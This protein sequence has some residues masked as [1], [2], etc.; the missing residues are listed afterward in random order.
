MLIP[1]PLDPELQVLRE[2]GYAEVANQR[3]PCLLSSGA[4]TFMWSLM[5]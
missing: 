2:A 1:K 5:D 4:L 3:V